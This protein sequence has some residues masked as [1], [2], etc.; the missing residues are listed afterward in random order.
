M[1]K[2]LN[3]AQAQS[4]IAVSSSF[5]FKAE[6]SYNARNLDSSSRSVK[7]ECNLPEICCQETGSCS[8]P[9]SVT[10]STLRINQNIQAVLS[11]KCTFENSLYVCQVIVGKTIE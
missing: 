7:F 6:Q 4:G 3:T 10:P 9:F 1:E 2:Q 8:K 11:S 5:N